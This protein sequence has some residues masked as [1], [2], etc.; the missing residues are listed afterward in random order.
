MARARVN[1]NRAGVVDLL[2]APG[3]RA[4]LERQAQ[5]VAAAARAAAPVRTGAYRDSIRV[6]VGVSPV[7]GRARA[8]V[9]A[10]VD[11]A[12]G[13]EARTGTLARALNV[14]GGP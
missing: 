6:E 11:Y 7:D 13:V 8:V 14:T 3:V 4:E 2:N 12:A 9:R 5:A 1:L 10:G